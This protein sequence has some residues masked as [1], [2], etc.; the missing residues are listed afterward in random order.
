MADT[1]AQPVAFTKCASSSLPVVLR[2]PWEGGCETKVA[3]GCGER[4]GQ[5]QGAW[6]VLAGTEERTQPPRGMETGE[7]NRRQE[8]QLTSRPHDMRPAGDV[9]L[10]ESFWGPRRN[11]CFLRSVRVDFF[12]SQTPTLTASRIRPFLA[13]VLGSGLNVGPSL[14][15][16]SR[17]PQ[18]WGPR[19]S[20]DRRACWAGAL[21]PAWSWGPAP[22]PRPPGLLS[23]SPMSSLLHQLESF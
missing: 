16:H 2:G 11:Q 17:C 18:E 5:L 22:P 12:P 8:Y 15:M 6:D 7:A 21:D 9:R 3:G 1:F 13:V 10:A 23:D 4:K 20:A 19:C 14:A